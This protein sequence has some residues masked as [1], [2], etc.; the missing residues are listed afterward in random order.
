MFNPRI[1]GRPSFGGINYDGRH[2]MR[3]CSLFR[4]GGASDR[5]R[6]NVVARVKVQLEFKKRMADDPSE[7]ARAEYVFGPW[8]SLCMGSTEEEGDDHGEPMP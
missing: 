2:L 5:E 7:V 4:A 1:Y 8:P 3:T 6:L